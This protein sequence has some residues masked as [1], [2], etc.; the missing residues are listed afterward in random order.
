MCDSGVSMLIIQKPSRKCYL[1][2]DWFNVVVVW[3]IACT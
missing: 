1:H 3:V 2:D